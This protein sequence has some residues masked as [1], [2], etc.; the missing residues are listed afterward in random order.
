MR[1]SFG[2]LTLASGFCGLLALSFF[3]TRGDAQPNTVKQIAPGVWF[4]EGDL[5]HLGHCNNVIIE[6]ADYLIV[7]DANFPSGARLAMEDA[8]KLSPK[9]V[10]YVFITHHHGDH[11][12]GS[13][14][15][16]ANGATTLAYKG[17]VEEMKRYEPARWQAAAKSRKDVAELHRDAPEYPKQTFD[18]SP[19]TLKDSTREV[20]FLFLGWAH[21]RGD[22]FAWLPKERVLCTGDAAANGPYNY[23][24]D[25]NIG[26]WPAVMAAAE[27]LSPAHV[28][29]GHGP[30]GGEE[31]L[32]GQARFM[33]EL[34]AAVE[35]EVKKGAKLEAIVTM[36]NGAPA[37]TTI[38]LPADVKNWV[39][40]SLPAQVADAYKE[41]TQGKSA[42]LLPHS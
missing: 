1:F 32:A 27:K 23:T 4:R 13:A 5:K 17:V 36:K 35:R 3:I 18:K 30:A 20:Q 34:R 24:A 8:R 12:Y 16:T 31:V 38:V 33:R 25:G 22:G 28:L 37:S 14:V 42:G 11:D 26:N 15:W 2:R 6:M 41:V 10:K 7:V 29:P 39:G 9:P 21:T 40:D 19:F